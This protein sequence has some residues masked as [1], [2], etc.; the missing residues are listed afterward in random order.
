MRSFL[1]LLVLTSNV[2]A[3]VI[4]TC[5][6]RHIIRAAMADKYDA[7]AFGWGEAFDR[8]NH[9]YESR[10]QHDTPPDVHQLS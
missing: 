4:G 5:G 9:G 8:Y 1:C 6:T 10:S 2:E 7:G 3:F